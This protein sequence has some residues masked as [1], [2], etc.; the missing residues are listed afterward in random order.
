MYEKDRLL[1]YESMD[2]VPTKLQVT[3]LKNNKKGVVTKKF[4][5][6]VGHV[7]RN[8]KER[9]TENQRQREVLSAVLC[10]CVRCHVV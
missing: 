7:Q 1:V 4:D 10:V 6:H 8:E 3:K 9:K 2:K 5:E